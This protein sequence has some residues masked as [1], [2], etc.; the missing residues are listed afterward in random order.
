M[1]QCVSRRTRAVITCPGGSPV[2]RTPRRFLAALALGT[3]VLLLPGV[4][5]AKGGGD[6][7]GTVEDGGG[8]GAVTGDFAVT[9]NGRTSNPA[10]GKDLRVSGVTPTSPVLLT[11]R[12]VRFRIDPATL[13]VHDYTQIGRAHV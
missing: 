3:A 4:A 12:H 7:G 5:Q 13:G 6:D 11:G 1:H 8:G 9:V 10:A 2:S